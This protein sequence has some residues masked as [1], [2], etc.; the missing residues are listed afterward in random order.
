MH[1][2]EYMHGALG[3]RLE[4][5]DEAYAMFGLVGEVGEICSK[6][7]KG[8]RDQKDI[9]PEDMKKEL[10]DVLWFVAALG[11]DFGYTLE[12]IAQANL[13]KLSGRKDRGTIQGSGDNR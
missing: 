12:D 3:Y 1:L 8:I 5:A 10:G 11:K 7:A 4:T 13:D 6:I 9:D 2:N